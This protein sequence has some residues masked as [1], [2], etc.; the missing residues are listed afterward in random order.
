MRVVR[1]LALALVAVALAA[2]VAA[3]RP[4]ARRVKLYRAGEVFCTDRVLVWGTGAVVVRDRCYVVGLV[5][6]REG[7]FLAFLDPA[8]HVPPGQIVRLSTPAGAKLRGRIFYLVP[9]QAVV[10]VPV[11]TLV[12]VPVRVEEED[13]R[14]TVILTGPQAPNLT[15]IFSVRL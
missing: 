5:R 2:G 9:V 14:L 10:A 6:N 11:D 4:K 8:V 15:V 7:T 1:G 12:I 13:S 3:A